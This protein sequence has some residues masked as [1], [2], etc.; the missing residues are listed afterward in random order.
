MRHRKFQISCKPIEQCDVWLWRKLL[1]L[2]GI[3]SPL[4]SF[5]VVSHM[6]HDVLHG[7]VSSSDKGFGSYKPVALTRR[8][9]MKNRGQLRTLFEI[10]ERD[11]CYLRNGRVIQGVSFGSF[12][13]H[14]QNV[15]DFSCQ[16]VTIYFINKNSEK[17]SYKCK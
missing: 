14:I 10:T 4:Y 1:S 15:P 11:S 2:Q 12:T 13:L 8:V 3:D 6:S 7:I 5:P 16:I 9:E 17:R